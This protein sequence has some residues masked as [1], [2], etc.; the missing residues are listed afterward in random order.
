MIG[1]QLQENTSTSSGRTGVGSPRPQ[2]EA[3]SPGSEQLCKGN[4]A[5]RGRTVLQALSATAA[6]LLAC[7]IVAL[8]L[9]NVIS[10]WYGPMLQIYSMLAAFYVLSRI[11]MSMCY[12]EPPDMGLIKSISIVMPVK[13]EE[14]HIESVIRQC[15][16]ARYPSDNRELIVVDDGSTDDTW[17]ILERLS[18][19]FTG[20]QVRRLER[21]MGKRHAI[22]AGLQL[23]HGEILIFMDSDSLVDLDGLYHIIQPFSDPTVGAVAGHTLIS[24]SGDSAIS[25]IE[26]VRYYISQRIMKAAESL[27]GAV[28]CCPG[29]FSAYRRD[30]VLQELPAW[31]DQ[32]FLGAP[33]TFGDDRSLTN[34]VLKWYRVIYHSG[35]R[36]TTFAPP[37]L[38]TLL[39]QQLRWKKS[40]AR[41]TTIAVRHMWR[42][43]PLAA[44][45]YYLGVLVT[46]VSPLVV[47]RVFFFLPWLFGP[48]VCIPYIA[49]L[50]LVFLLLGTLHYYHSRSPYWH[51]GIV[52]AVLYSWLFSLQTYYAILTVR[53]AHW[54]TR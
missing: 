5:P 28:S 35:A 45:P 18:R 21:N 47:L 3:L 1:L 10:F 52:F 15:F 25:K 9:R 2:S 40:W 39:K 48:T 49:G 30:V 44:L 4:A 42:E 27:F 32:T 12:R 11:F 20:L 14:K 41:E 24:V 46:L 23:A 50:F 13:N 54:G 7:L 22:A 33:A 17:Q 38:R 19:E 16:R 43:H 29:P 34:R 37:D 53:R 6:F 26:S 36:C 31:L 51:Y 8:K